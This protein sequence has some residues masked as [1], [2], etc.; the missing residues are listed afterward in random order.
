[1]H[2]C[3]P[4]WSSTTFGW[5]I[6]VTLVLVVGETVNL[7][8]TVPYWVKTTVKA[9]K[10]QEVCYSQPFWGFDQAKMFYTNSKQAANMHDRIQCF[11][12]TRRHLMPLRHTPAN[13]ECR[14]LNTHYKM[15]RETIR[16]GSGPITHGCKSKMH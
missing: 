13:K 6:N 15:G 14:V 2:R 12:K 1:M 8:C 5:S 4:T 3:S 11:L 7:R 10:V 9:M 16:W